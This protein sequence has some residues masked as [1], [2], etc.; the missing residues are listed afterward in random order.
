MNR[1]TI[2]QLI[3]I[4]NDFYQSQASS[5][6][7]TRQSAWLGWQRCADV[8]RTWGLVDGASG[9]PVR[10]FDL[11]C[12]NLRFEA[13]LQQT[14]PATA[15][16]FW[17]VDACDALVA[18]ACV[19]ADAVHYQ[20]LDI[21]RALL[22]ECGV[23]SGDSRVD[24]GNA[25][26]MAARV[27]ARMEAPACDI[28]VAFG[29]LHHLPT[30]S[31][32]VQVL[33]TLVDKTRIGGVIAVSFWCF[34]RDAGLAAR[35]HEV[36]AQALAACAVD[37]SELD[38]GDFLLGWKHTPGAYRY[39]HSFCDAEIDALVDALGERVHVLDRFDA[40]GRSGNLNTYVVLQVCA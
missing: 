36:H 40:D 8:A 39:C 29:F 18:D 34:M 13:F 21:T 25:G 15:F 26:R 30:V 11:A 23:L 38:E 22:E 17:P 12:G 33:Q 31:L 27:S 14:F 35:A 4:T 10:V 5:F 7:E 24:D 1:K 3:A 9:A 28:A 2:E 32:R 6:S 16:E 37:A 19:D 20:Q